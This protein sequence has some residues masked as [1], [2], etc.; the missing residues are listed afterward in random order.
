M[1]ERARTHTHSH[2]HIHTYIHTYSYIYI[3]IYYFMYKVSMFARLSVLKFY[4][5]S[6]VYSVDPFH[7][8]NSLLSH[9]YSYFLHPG[10][11]RSFFSSSSRWTPFKNFSRLPFFAYSSH[12]TI[13]VQIV[14][15]VCNVTP[16]S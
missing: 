4:L 2:T 10:I 1:R 12:V 7:I 6:P 15:I 8:F 16:N 3:Y 5:S 13:P 9:S 14:Y 11:S